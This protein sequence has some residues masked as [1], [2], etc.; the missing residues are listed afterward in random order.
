MLKI[1]DAKKNGISLHMALFFFL[2]VFEFSMASLW[3]L[4]FLKG[5]LRACVYTE[6]FLY[7]V[8]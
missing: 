1:I 6:Y 8:Y 4:S 3:S 5:T 7:K 2:S